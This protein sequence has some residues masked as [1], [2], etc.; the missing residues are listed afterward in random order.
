[1]L[2]PLDSTRF[3]YKG[4]EFKLDWKAGTDALTRVFARPDPLLSGHYG[5][6]SPARRS[7]SARGCQ[8]YRL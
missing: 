6:Y 2:D 7:R 3:Y 5:N 8:H 4:M 1:M